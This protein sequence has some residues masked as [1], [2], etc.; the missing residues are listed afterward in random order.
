MVATK[1]NPSGGLRSSRVR[2]GQRNPE[3]TNRYRIANGFAG[4]IFK[5]DAVA[6]NT[7]NGTITQVSGT[8]NI[9]SN[10]P[11]GVFMGHS[12]VDPVTRRPTWSSMFIAGTSSAVGQPQALV[13]DNPDQTFVIQADASISAG[14]IGLNFE[15]SLAQGSSFTQTSG[16]LLR[17]ASRGT[18]TGALRLVDIYEIPGNALAPDTSVTDAFPF[19]EVQWNQNRN[20][21]VSAA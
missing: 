20:T 4:N 7:A 15:L 17:A 19:V 16:F 6:L 11:I 18:A 10:R 21:I 5:G 8:G 14:D 3:A 9:N 12:Y 13:I 2:G 1:Y